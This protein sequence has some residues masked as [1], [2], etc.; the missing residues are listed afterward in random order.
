MRR[1]PA[2]LIKHFSID[3]TSPPTYIGK[4]ILP[5][6]VFMDD[7]IA[8]LTKVNGCC[9]QV[10]DI[11]A[12]AAYIAR[13]SDGPLLLPP[14]PSLLRIGLREE[15]VRAGL[16][17]IDN[18]WRAQA[19]TADSGITG[20]NF[21]IA[22]TGSIV[23]D[24]TQEAVRLASTLPERHFVLLDPAKILPEATDGIP[25]VR[26]IHQETPQTYLAYITGPSRTADIERVLTIGVHGPAE[27]HILLLPGLSDDPMES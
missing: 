15:L 21:A 1:K 19:P 23:L 2:I 13:H 10:A 3:G 4:T 11:G 14:Q 9:E 27:L 12:A 22:A 18:D 17:V 16:P 5:K 8:A 25:I 7:F 20:A 26:R 24:S 6:E